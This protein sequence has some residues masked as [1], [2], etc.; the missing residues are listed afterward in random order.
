M[1]APKGDIKTKT[2]THTDSESSSKE[3]NESERKIATHDSERNMKID[4]DSPRTN[5][6]ERTIKSLAYKKVAN[7]MR[8]IATTLPEEF[9][10]V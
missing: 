2:I 10:I 1:Q 4:I 6:S 3:T 8:P 9:R 5:E 7:K